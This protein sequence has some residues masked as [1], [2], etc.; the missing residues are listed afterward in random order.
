[1]FERVIAA[2]CITSILAGGA[3][4][5]TLIWGTPTQLM[6][7]LFSSSLLLFIVTG[8]IFSIVVSLRTRNQ[9]SKE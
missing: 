2:I 3:L 4:G 1:M 7:N 9:T 5:F 6:G 8:S